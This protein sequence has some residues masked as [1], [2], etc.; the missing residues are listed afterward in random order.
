MKLFAN[1]LRGGLY[2]PALVCLALLTV[3]SRPASASAPSVISAASA[4]SANSLW[5]EVNEADFSAT[6]ARWIIPERY[7]TLALD[8]DTLAAG[9]AEA[10]LEFTPAA[11]RELPVIVL[12]LPDG[13]YG[14]F[15]FVDSPVMAAELAVQFSQMKTYAAV[16][17]DDP[18]G[19]ARFDWTLHGFHAM[20]LSPSGTI[21]IDPYQRGDTAHYISYFARDFSRAEVFH[22]YGPLSVVPPL[23]K[24]VEGQARWTSGTELRTYQT[25]IAA[26]G[27]YTQYFGGT[28]PDA[29]AEITTLINRISAVYER[30][31]AVRMQLIANETAI[32]YTDPTKD[33]YTNGDGYA[34]LGQNQANLD[35]VIGS[36]NYDFGHVVST[37]N[38]GGLA[39]LG[40]PC[41]AYWKAQG[42]TGSP[43]PTG[44]PFYVDYVAHEM[45]HQFGANHSFN[46]NEGACAGVNRNPGTAYEPGS[47]STIMSYAGICGSQ[48]LQPHSDDYF[49]TISFD[50]IIAY[51]TAGDG[52]TCAEVTYTGNLPPEVE[53]GTGGFTIPKGTPFSLQGLVSDP[54]GD[55]L[56]YSWEE[57]D[58]G[59]AGHPNSPA[60]NAPIFRSF[61]AVMIPERIFPR[62]SD[63]LG[64]THTIGEL[65]P[66]YTRILTF[67]LT[68]RDNHISPSAGGVA[69]DTIA[70]NVTGNAGPFLVTYPNT[71]VTW[72]AATTETVTWN[73]ASTN[74]S[75]VNCASVDLLLSTDGGYTFP[76]T[77]TAG[78]PNDGAQNITVP[79]TETT[80]ARLK[81]ACATSIFFDLSNENFTIE[82]PA[83]PI[84][85]VTKWISPAM[86]LQPGVGVDYWI[87][88]MNLAE[89]ATATVTDDFPAGI[90]EPSC[91]GIPGNLYWAGQLDL[92]EKI[93]FACSGTVDSALQVAV[94]ETVDREMVW[95]GE[96]VTFTLVVANPSEALA[97]TQVSVT[98][99]E[100]AGC[101]G[102]GDPF[103]LNTLE[104]RTFVCPNT[105]I[106]HNLTSTVTVTATSTLTNTAWVDAPGM[107]DGPKSAAVSSSVSLQGGDSVAVTVKRWLIMYLP[108][109]SIG[110]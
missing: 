22:E 40:V 38:G 58:L 84:L 2:I 88:V 16:G 78:V 85:E 59:P 25:A 104:S 68:A 57:F 7:R 31:V 102:L 87:E 12:P 39:Y 50:E 71:P 23:D 56:T 105:V 48:D 92:G 18:S 54:D 75:P 52:N 4:N 79:F 14:R 89:V 9:L 45:G 35:A 67:R 55:P 95:P 34:M 20:I 103:N 46:G 106:T 70:F 100:L 10:P 60:L 96:A 108:W 41:D 36:N 82:K 81:V 64:N 3:L 47:G 77:I 42:V 8:L 61:L 73:V 91:D 24:Q 76:I 69:Y 15:R 66:S 33:P 43:N 101:A 99:P 32:I 98:A 53:A 94:T 6:G 109:L 17:I 62:Q 49:H 21:Y 26:T 19:Y 90:V 37:W 44:D 65:L 28:V 107:P 80:Q 30:E 97:L 83:Y 1:T 72:Q 74:I 11:Q 86:I 51:T 63:L 110:D 27:E 13:G 93:T 5:Q 29:L